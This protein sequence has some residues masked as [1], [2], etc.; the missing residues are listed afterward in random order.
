M[1]ETNFFLVNYQGTLVS[2]RMLFVSSAQG[3]D[4]TSPPFLEDSLRRN[5]KMLCARC[6]VRDPFCASLWNTGMWGTLLV[7]GGNSN[8]R[9]SF[10]PPPKERER[11]TV[12]CRESPSFFFV[13]V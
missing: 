13:C 2:Q 12:W 6:S 5:C 8:F 7:S 9:Y 11:E 3:L 4:S 1:E 10:S